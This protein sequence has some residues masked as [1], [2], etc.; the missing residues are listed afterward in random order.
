M[1]G[2]IISAVMFRQKGCMFI[3]TFTN[4]LSCVVVDV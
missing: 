3:H 4:K 1:H 2:E